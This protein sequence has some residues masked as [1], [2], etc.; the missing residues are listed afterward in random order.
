MVLSGREKGDGY[1]SQG[2]GV[3]G[4][5]QATGQ[6]SACFIFPNPAETFPG[7][8]GTAHGTASEGSTFV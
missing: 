1:G 3:G 4:T 8:R 6:I 7:E 2:P 5:V